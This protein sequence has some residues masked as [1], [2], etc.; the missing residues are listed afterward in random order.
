MRGERSQDIRG[1]V[2]R[3]EIEFLFPVLGTYRNV[4]L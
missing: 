3:E 4:E 1:F 2:T